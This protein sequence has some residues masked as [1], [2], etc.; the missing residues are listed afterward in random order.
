MMRWVGLGV[1]AV[2]LGIGTGCA[3]TCNRGD[4]F[5]EPRLVDGVERGLDSSFVRI[6]WDVG[7]RVGAELG[8]D[9]F[10]AVTVGE[11]SDEGGCVVEAARYE[12]PRTLIVD[13]C[14]RTVA[15]EGETWTFSLMFPDRRDF[16]ECTHPGQSDQTAL[17]V[18]LTFDS[19]GALVST[20]FDEQLIA[21]AL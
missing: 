9:Y 12:A 8:D 16:V 14:D 3:D 6:T 10:A 19:S 17:A 7:T 11:G 2:G 21:G 15:A 13:L 18:A 1:V 4:A 20:D 5:S